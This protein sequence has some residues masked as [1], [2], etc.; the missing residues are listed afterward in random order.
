MQEDFNHIYGAGMRH[1]QVKTADG[2]VYD[3]DAIIN[4]EGDPQQEDTTIKGDDVVKATLS[5]NRTE[6]ITISANAVSMD[7][8]KAITG[9]E[10][11]KDGT[12]GASI[13]L[14][15]VSELNAPYVEVAGF[16]NARTE[17]GTAVKVSKTWHKVQLNKTKITAGNGN[18]LAVEISG[19]A[20]QTAKDVAGQALPSV[21]V[22]TLKVEKGQA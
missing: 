22:A 3:I 16:I 8:L 5:S 11:T 14:G 6:D 1:G 10:I 2:T 9:N 21:R 4:I 18:E 20:V 7:V 19:S 12:N 13:A 15:T 17:G